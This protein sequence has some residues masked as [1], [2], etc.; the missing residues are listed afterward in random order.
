M[1]LVA[2]RE[3]GDQKELQQSKTLLRSPNKIIC[4][5]QV[6]HAPAEKARRA[7][8]QTLFKPRRPLRPPR[9][10]PRS[11]HAARSPSPPQRW[12]TLIPGTSSWSGPCSSSAPTPTPYAVVARSPLLLPEFLPASFRVSDPTKPV[13]ARVSA[14]PLRDEVP[15]LRG[16]AR[17]QGHRRPRGTTTLSKLYLLRLDLCVCSLVRSTDDG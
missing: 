7:A 10:P 16:E 17:A 11:G 8:K 3:N 12:C 13:C 1:V 5:T 6:Q 4:G 15:A 2:Q 14:D 9:F